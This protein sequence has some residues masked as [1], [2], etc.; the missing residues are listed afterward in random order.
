MNVETWCEERE[1]G[2]TEREGRDEKERRREDVENLSPVMKIKPTSSWHRLPQKGWRGKGEESEK[3]R[4]EAFLSSE[5]TKISLYIHLS[6][7]LTLSLSLYTARPAFFTTTCK[8]KEPAEWVVEYTYISTYRRKTSSNYINRLQLNPP[9]TQIYL[10]INKKKKTAQKKR[11]ILGGKEAIDSLLPSLLLATLE[12]VLLI[13]TH[14]SPWWGAL[15]E[16]PWE[17]PEIMKGMDGWKR[18]VMD[19][20]IWRR[21]WRRCMYT[22]T[23]KE[24]REEVVR[25][26]TGTT[27]DRI[28]EMTIAAGFDVE[29]TEAKDVFDIWRW[30]TYG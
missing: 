2:L 30:P 19:V 18:H 26:I 11:R 8:E 10:H 14:M 17:K 9:P 28:G 6:F 27:S 5:T 22:R 23:R 4:T 16:E 29:R 21:P 20:W 3:R 15:D 7:L 13:W 12:S 25:Q 24:W 1:A